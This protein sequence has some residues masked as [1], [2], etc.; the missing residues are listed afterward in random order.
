MAWR[1]ALGSA[2]FDVGWGN[3]PPTLS[4]PIARE[5]DRAGSAFGRCARAQPHYPQI[6]ARNWTACSPCKNVLPRNTRIACCGA[7]AS[8]EIPV[9]ACLW[10]L[11]EV[12]LIRGRQHVTC[13][14][15]D[16]DV[17][18]LRDARVEPW[19]N[20]HGDL[21]GEPHALNRTG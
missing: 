7:S 5:P 15:Y 8:R 11:I 16:L 14:R 13:V 19:G 9:A 6:A 18:G 3:H 12:Q 21:I 20:L 17:V 1:K 4:S 10:K 2:G